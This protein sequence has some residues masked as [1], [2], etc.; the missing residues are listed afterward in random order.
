MT[1]EPGSLRKIVGRGVFWSVLQNWGGKFLTF[2]LSILLARLLSPEEFGVASAAWL[3]LLLVP[4]IA[5]MGFGDAILQ[6]R[7]LGNADLNLPF[8]LATA[9]AMILVAAVVAWRD[10]IAAWAG[11][12]AGSGYLVAIA[13]T[14]LLSVPN[15][16]Q[17]AM[18]KRNM[19]FRALALR[20]LVSNVCGGLVA[21]AAAAAGF[22][23]WSFVLQAWVALAINVVWIWARP[24]WWPGLVCEGRAL[25]GMLRFGLPVVAQRLVDFCGTRTLDFVIIAKVGLTGYG[26]YVVGS[27][28]YLTMMQLLQG[29]FR[30]VS[31]TV[32]ST[33]AHDRRR[34]ADIYTETIALSALT[35]SPFFVLVAALSPE[36][37]AVLFGQA[38]EGVDRIAQL[39]LLMGAIHC[40]QYMNGAFLAARG[41]PELVLITGLTKSLLQIAAVLLLGGETVAG[42][43]GVFVL[44]AICATPLSFLVTARELGL[45]VVTV[46][47]ILLRPALMSAGGFLA[48]WLVRPLITG[49]IPD[50]G[51]FWHGALLGLVFALAHLALLA[52]LDR[53]RAAMLIAL[54]RRR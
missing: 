37:C 33:I 46:A 18:Y 31:L 52:L 15:A 49:L 41:K 24:Q 40:V 28:F 26:L 4:L 39:L 3:A 1:G 32:L 45:P 54:L 11:L 17:E 6:R 5:E 48:V 27:R 44:A 35:M 51:T 42:L 30:D 19:K 34:I 12:G 13:G 47:G 53:R 8:W 25:G 50:F 9:V 29:A 43:T 23:I 14:I 10:P 2:A 21:L 22:G 7:E 36:I 20:G 16:F 38:W